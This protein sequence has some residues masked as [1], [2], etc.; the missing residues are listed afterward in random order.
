MRHSWPLSLLFFH[1]A[2]CSSFP[3]SF[4]NHS[5]VLGTLTVSIGKYKWQL[6]LIMYLNI[7]GNAI[8]VITGKYYYETTN[9]TRYPLFLLMPLIVSWVKN[10]VKCHG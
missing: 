10:M 5:L 9:V 4:R 3:R 2:F 8:S 6:T 1:S 7:K